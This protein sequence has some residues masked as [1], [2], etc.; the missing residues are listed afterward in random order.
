MFANDV[1]SKHG[2]IIPAEVEGCLDI[3]HEAM[4]LLNRLS[5]PQYNQI[6]EPFLQS[7]I[8]QHMR[9]ILD[10]FHATMSWPHCEI[11]D[12]DIRRRTHMVEKDKSMAIDEWQGITQWLK[13]IECDQLNKRLEV[14]NEVNATRQISV[15]SHSTFARELSFI[16]THAVHHFALIR[17]SLFYQ[18]I[19]SGDTFGMAPTTATYYR[20]GE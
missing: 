1:P 20:R 14:K 4:N 19:S 16:S 2:L 12:Y 9:H 8:G 6:A 10:V 17:V 13:G 3:A 15:L 7:S 11:I 5:A 18:G